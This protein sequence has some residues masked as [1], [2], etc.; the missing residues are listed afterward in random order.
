MLDLFY[1]GTNGVPE[2][3]LTRLVGN[4]KEN[5]P[6]VQISVMLFEVNA[7]TFSNLFDVQ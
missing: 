6:E 1:R 4:K 2:C 5:K 3:M 7:P